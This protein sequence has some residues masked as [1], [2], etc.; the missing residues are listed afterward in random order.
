MLAFLVLSLARD[1]AGSARCPVPLVLHRVQE[2][3]LRP[4][5]CG[6]PAV[7]SEGR[8][9]LSLPRVSSAELVCVEAASSQ[10]HLLGIPRRGGWA[11]L[12]AGHT[13]C[14]L[15][16][17]PREDS[18][19]GIGALGYVCMCVGFPCLE[20]GLLAA[21]PWGSVCIH[22]ARELGAPPYLMAHQS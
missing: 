2:A 13:L 1:L 10:P 12:A 16:Q 7:L 6:G 5:P 15:E 8:W 3:D 21:R 20:I 11:T 17:P 14:G 19:P 22:Q 18:E 9:C 4:C